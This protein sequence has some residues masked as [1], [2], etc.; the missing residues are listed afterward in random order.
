M[1][2]DPNPLEASQSWAMQAAGGW[3]FSAQFFILS[4][5]PGSG[6]TT[7]LKHCA[8]QMRQRGLTVGGVLVPVAENGRRQLQL[9]ST[10][11]ELLQ[12]QLND[13]QPGD[14]AGCAHEEE[15]APAGSIRVGNFVF[16]EHVFAKARSEL[17][18][19]RGQDRGLAAA[20]AD[21]IIVDEIGPLELNR[22]QGLEPA[23]GELLRAAARGELGPPQ[24]RFLIVARAAL[25][26]TMVQTYGLDGTGMPQ[27]DGDGLFPGFGG[28]EARAAAV[29][30]LDVPEP[31]DATD[32]LVGRLAGL[33]PLL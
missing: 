16:D 7:F 25:R 31:G 1:A 9:L 3:S 21:W 20:P 4:A 2:G 17:Q 6:K 5:P 10:P 23:V 29:V 33:P 18:A 12:L 14:G 15:Q 19:L 8:E 26:D 32:A 13:G 27:D 30:D 11:G 24:S 22:G 28:P